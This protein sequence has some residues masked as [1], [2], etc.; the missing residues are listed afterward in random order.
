[1]VAAVGGRSVRTHRLAEQAGLELVPSLDDVVG[2]AGVVLSVVPPA[3]AVP[4][5]EAIGA[6]AVRSGAQPLVADL[7]AVSPA[8]AIR[9]A[10][11][12]ASHGIGLVDGSI[13]GPPPSEGD[14]APTRVYL[15]GRRAG[16]I[17]VLQA[18]GLELRTVGPQ[19]GSASAVKMSTAS[20]YKGRAAVL[21]QAL[22]AAHRNGVL[23]PVLDDL[24]DA[25]P[26]I[27]DRGGSTLARA[28]AKSG[29]YVGEMREIAATQEAAGLTPALFDAMA[30]VY[31]A[32]AASPV[33]RGAPEDVDPSVS[34]DDVLRAVEGGSP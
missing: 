7:N 11:V 34:L 20:V 8:T 17:A 18:P 16:E 13:S 27:R 1:V 33:G 21:W 6:A 5:A 19:I 15:S 26:E 2:V 3:E 4:V 25:Y 24:R 14:R 9:I 32:L 30:E 12:L 29:R 22:L 28:A 23:E 10:S 31:E